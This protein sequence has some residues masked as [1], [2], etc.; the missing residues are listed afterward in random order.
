MKSMTAYG[1]FSSQLE[2]GHIVVEIQSVNRKHLDI[3]LSL[4]SELAHFDIEVKKWIASHFFR[5]QITVKVTASF[6]NQIPFKVLPNLPLAKQA[7]EAWEEIADYLH[8]EKKPFDLSMLVSLP[9]ILLLEENSECQE[10]YQSYLKSAVEGALKQ[11][12]AMKKAEGTIFQK[13]IAQRLKIMHTKMSAIEQRAPVA[14]Q[15]YR[16]KLI[17]RLQ[18]FLPDQI[19]NE[20]R[21]LREIALFAEKI[22][23]TE[24]ITR[25]FCHLCRF[26]ELMQTS[27][28]SVGKT[29]E[30][31]TQEL[32]REANTIASKS[33]DIEISR[34]VIEIK[35]EL[36]RIKEQLHNI[37]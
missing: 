11:C 23:I 26:E 14:P 4:P 21:I 15:K 29:L 22:D 17:N 13:D 20:E 7:K 3:S 24:E 27:L 37:E 5:G 12:L 2:V 18:E 10:N 30:F 32:A 6:Q 8:L 25:F 9:D 34:D 31:I 1:R 16:E 33:F 28:Q 35:S 36:E 19:E